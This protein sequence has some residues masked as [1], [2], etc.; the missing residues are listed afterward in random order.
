[1]TLLK[2]KIELIISTMPLPA[3]GR[4]DR[5]IGHRCISANTKQLHSSSMRMCRS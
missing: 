3:L 2:M 1:M 4:I 5:N